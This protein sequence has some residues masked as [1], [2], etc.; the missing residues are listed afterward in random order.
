MKK[1]FLSILGVGLLLVGFSSC[2]E[3]TFDV[4]SDEFTGGATTIDPTVYHGKVDSIPYWTVPSQEN[5]SAAISELR[6]NFGQYKSAQY[7]LRGGKDGNPPAS[8][9]YQYVYTMTVDNYSGY[10]VVPHRDFLYGPALPTTYSDVVNY[11]DGPYG[12]LLGVKG[13]IINTLNHPTIDSIPEMKA[14]GL[15]LFNMSAQEQVDLYGAIPYVDHKNNKESNPFTFNKME[16]IYSTIVDNLDTIITC[17]EHF[18]TKPDWYKSTVN[19]LLSQYD[20]CTK[21]RSFASWKRLANSLKLRMAMHVVKV[22]PGTAKKWA[23]EAV[24]SGVIE[25]RNQELLFDAMILGCTH[26]LFQ[27]GN[28]WGDTRLNASLVNMLHCLK[29]PYLDYLFEKNSHA[30]GNMPANTEVIGLRAG[31]Q[32]GDGQTIAQNPLQAYSQIKADGPLAMASLYLMK[33]SEV[34]F[35]RAEGALRGWA[36]GGDASYFYE[37]GIRNGQ[38]DERNGTFSTA[39]AD[40]IDAYLAVETPVA[41]DYVDPLD[42]NNNHPSVTTIGV[43]WN[44]NDSR[45]V[46]LEKIITQKYIAGFPNSYEAWNDLRRTGYPKIFPVL[47]PELGD[48]SLSYGDLIRKIPLP[49]RDLQEGLDDI[50]NSGIDAL[51]RGTDNQATRVWWDVEGAGNF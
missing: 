29:H 10:F 51:G 48:G 36:M 2:S 38:M 16:T 11:C 3:S 34:Q 22:A 42:A 31:I 19:S 12:A 9:C 7:Y 20:Q 5:L 45:E 28:T 27:I 8:H 50:A 49:G 30:I 32:V 41:H 33:L 40:G 37:Q 18:E 26:P 13:C 24:A 17:F 1:S 43:K 35:L 39:Y 25:E 4:P 6:T 47:N 44:E 23:E 14:W 46:K 15:L 21:D